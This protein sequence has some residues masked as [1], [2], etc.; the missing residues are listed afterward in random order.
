MKELKEMAFI[1][2]LSA[3]SMHTAV[4]WVMFLLYARRLSMPIVYEA[5]SFVVSPVSSTLTESL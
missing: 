4:A 1:G 5:L 2:V 3:A